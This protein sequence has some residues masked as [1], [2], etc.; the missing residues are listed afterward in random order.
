MVTSVKSGA[1]VSLKNVTINKGGI[2]ILHDVTM[3]ISV[4]SSIALLG[5]SGCGK[6]TLLRVIAGLEKVV[7]G[8]I[9]IDNEKPCELYKSQALMFL[10]QEPRLWKHLTVNE[11][12]R[13][14]FKLHKR[15]ANEAEL[16]KILDQ[17]GL[18]DF[19]EYYPDALSV[20]MRAR[21]A[22]ARAFC[23][24]PRLLL[25]DEPF[26]A[27]DPVRRLRLN[28]QFRDLCKQDECTTI[29][30][31]HDIVE[32]MQFADKIIVFTDGESVRPGIIEFDLA[33]YSK[34]TDPAAI[35][36]DCLELRKSLLDRFFIN[37][38]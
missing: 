3:D 5:P 30:V 23:I 35:P 18:A 16:K 29:W 28:H 33:G 2:E 22:I 19:T 32:A 34:I 31:T 25:A 24:R 21:L 27:L 12:L 20:G 37:D 38:T 9:T 17:L 7:S 10:F 8:F 11:T 26:A 36:L 15:T 1:F 14:T 4:G 13:L 6:T